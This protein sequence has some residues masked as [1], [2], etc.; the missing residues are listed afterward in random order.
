VHQLLC[1]PLSV[2]HSQAN[3][4]TVRSPAA[5]TLSRG[6]RAQAEKATLAKQAGG[7]AGGGKGEKE[8]YAQVH[9]RRAGHT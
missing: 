4:Q 5:A 9:G 1:T 6:P 8:E 3:G 7:A 2:H